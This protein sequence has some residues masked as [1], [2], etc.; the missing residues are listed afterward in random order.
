MRKGLRATISL[1]RLSM[2]TNVPSRVASLV[3]T[4]SQHVSIS[5]LHSYQSLET[6]EIRIISLHPGRDPEPIR[7]SLRNVHLGDRVSYESVSYC[8][9]LNKPEAEVVCDDGVIPI[10]KNLYALIRRLRRQDDARN[11]WVD[12]MAIDQANVEERSQ[13][14]TLMKDIFQLSRC[15]VVWLGEEAQNSHLAMRLLRHL[16]Q[17]AEERG[18]HSWKSHVSRSLPPLYH[19]AWRALSELLQRPWFSR[20]WIVQEV[21]VSS[22]ILVVC[23]AESVPWDNFVR[24][25]Q[26][27]VDLGVFI[28]YG[29][30]TAFQVR[31]LFETRSDF[32][33]GWL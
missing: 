3:F 9:G 5:R 14:V 16:A 4:R 29:G 23:G 24:A 15:T 25:V 21:A 7:C 8:W 6:N 11:L 2:P 31:Q 28:A 20:A 10:T 33:G 13:Q 26:Y 27:A 30:S 19:P 32:Q 12:A 1:L 22:D 17:T 18:P